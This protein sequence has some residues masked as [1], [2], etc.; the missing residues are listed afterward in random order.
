M[1]SGTSAIH[2][3]T[4]MRDGMNFSE[5]GFVKPLLAWSRADG[6]RL[7]HEGAFADDILG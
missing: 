3:L 7:D 4:L 5:V 6:A 1:L 2:L